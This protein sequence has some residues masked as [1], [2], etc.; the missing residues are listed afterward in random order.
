MAEFSDNEV[1]RE[2]IG[3]LHTLKETNIIVERD[4]TKEERERKGTL[5]KI[6]REVLKRAAAQ[7]TSIKIVVSENKI[8]FEDQA[9]IYDK[10]AKSFNFSVDGQVIALRNYL[11]DTFDLVVDAKYSIIEEDL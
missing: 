5:L 10:N 2:I 4:L 1:V 7:N 11:A 8:K 3:K 9:F 6:R